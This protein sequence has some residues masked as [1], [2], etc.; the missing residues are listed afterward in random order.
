[1]TTDDSWDDDEDW[2][3]EDDQP[4]ERVASCPECGATIY[5]DAEMCP[6][7]GHWLSEADRRAIETGIVRSLWFKIAVVVVLIAFVTVF[8]LAIAF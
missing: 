2:C 1:M 3:D 5:A 4:D 7:C 8:V 6:K